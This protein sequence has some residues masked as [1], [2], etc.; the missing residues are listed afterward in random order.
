M[1]S[2]TCATLGYHATLPAMVKLLLGVHVAG[3]SVALLSMFIPILSRKGGPAHRRAG[4][5]FVGGMTVVCVTALLLSA[6]RFL[7]DASPVGREFSMLLFYIAILTGAGIWAGMRVLRA[8]DRQTRGAAIDIAMAGL[9]AG[10]G[11][12]TAG[13]GFATGHPLF[14]AF[15]LI[16]LIN[17]SAEL[18]YWLR[19]PTV[20]MHWWLAHMGNMLGACIAATTA[21]AIFGGRRLGIPG[22]SLLTWLGPTIIGLPTIFIWTRY[23]RRRFARTRVAS[24]SAAGRVVA[25]GEQVKTS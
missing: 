4:W 20:H 3:G 10:S 11:A 6:N 18:S 12:L 2:G 19:R 7:T 15:S 24:Q 21:F 13:Y 5:V 22:D 17:G 16:G 25:G 14:I 9:L 23:Y 8:K 1:T